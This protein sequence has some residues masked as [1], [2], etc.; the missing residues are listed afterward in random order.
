MGMSLN[1]KTFEKIYSAR[2]EFC[3]YDDYNWDWTL[4][5]CIPKMGGFRTLVAVAPRVFHVGNCKGPEGGTH[6]NKKTTACD[7][8]A[9]K[10]KF[11]EYTEKIKAPHHSVVFSRR[12]VA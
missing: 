4:Q 5:K 12:K 3:T 10:K 7:L 6:S 1:R 9:V 2:E 11:D 8:E